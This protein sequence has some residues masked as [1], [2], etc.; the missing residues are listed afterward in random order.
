MH[1]VGGGI[2]LEETF[3]ALLAL[4]MFFLVFPPPVICTAF[5]LCASFSEPGCICLRGVGECEPH[6]SNSF[7]HYLGMGQNESLWLPWFQLAGF[8]F[9][10]HF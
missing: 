6:D 3:Q 7:K 5:P 2:I 9:G 1:R 8:H 4:T 10:T